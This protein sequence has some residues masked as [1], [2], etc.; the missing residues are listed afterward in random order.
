MLHWSLTAGFH[1]AFILFGLAVSPHAHA[2][3]PKLS[4]VSVDSQSFALSWPGTALSYVLESVD[5]L[6]GASPWRPVAEQPTVINDELRLVLSTADRPRFFRLRF[7]SAG[8]PPDP[9]TVAPPL[10]RSGVTDLGSA[11]AFLYTGS[12]PI[13]TGVTN[14]TIESRRVAVLRGKVKERNNAPL[15]GVKISI[16]NHPEF[17][18]TLSRADG[19]FDLAVNGGACSL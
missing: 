1:T 17:G 9:A 6:A 13:Q 4:I 18:Q 16:L 2:Q 5:E 8:L 10:S 19:M 3:A 7:V 11:T 12:N 14:G 15:T